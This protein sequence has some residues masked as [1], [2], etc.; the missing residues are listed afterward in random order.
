MK[1]K[2]WFFYIKFIFIPINAH[3]TPLCLHTVITQSIV[4]QTVKF[5]ESLNRLPAYS[6]ANFRHKTLFP[7]ISSSHRLS[8]C[9]FV[10][11][12]VVVICFK[13]LQPLP[14][15]I[16]FASIYNIRHHCVLPRPLCCVNDTAHLH[17]SACYCFFFFFFAFTL[18]VCGCCC[19]FL[20]LL[21]IT[22]KCVEKCW[23]LLL[24]LRYKLNSP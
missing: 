8:V 10:P 7:T 23:F 9:L 3:H 21:V 13:I 15:Q 1:K 18:A 5:F 2:L 24:W 17:F 11:H 12:W 16:T 22:E 14:A 6:P 20:L 4:C 19:H